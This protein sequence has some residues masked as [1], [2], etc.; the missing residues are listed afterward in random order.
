MGQRPV[1]GECWN[2]WLF[3]ELHLRRQFPHAPASQF[4]CVDADV[5]VHHEDVS[6]FGTDHILVVEVA[7]VYFGGG[8][9][10]VFGVD[11]F[12]A[13]VLGKGRYFTIWDVSALYKSLLYNDFKLFICFSKT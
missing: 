9:C 10:P 4:W 13:H 11:L 5:A 7:Q 12:E 3:S 6:L 8:V 1:F 2:E